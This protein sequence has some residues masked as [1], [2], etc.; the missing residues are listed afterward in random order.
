MTTQNLAYG[1]WLSIDIIG[2]VQRLTTGAFN[3]VL[4]AESHLKSSS[5]GLAVTFEVYVR[6]IKLL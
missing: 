1:G 3:P 6:Y 2:N 4:N 5:F